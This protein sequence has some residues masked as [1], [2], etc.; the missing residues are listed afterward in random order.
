MKR[1]LCLFIAVLFVAPS[2]MAGVFEVPVKLPVKARLKLDKGTQLALAPFVIVISG[3][4]RTD[5]AARV[6]VQGEFARFAI[7]EIEKETD[8]KVIDATEERLPSSDMR[9][10]R[11]NRDFWKSIADKTGADFVIAGSID[12]D[13]EDKAG[14]RTEEYKSPVDGR[15]YYRQVLVESTGFVFD[16]VVMVFDGE[17]GE[18]LVEENYRDFKEFD[19][20][21]YD[22]LIGLFE[23]LRSMEKKL[24]GIFVSQE[25]TSTRYLFE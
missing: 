10:I 24:L 14:Y 21:D 4:D 6:D 5:R 7:K 2:S 19:E 12:F 25:T 15:V 16:I 13:I 22:E 9:E 23:N 8:L 1:A 20:R 18:K 11:A 17:T 3:E